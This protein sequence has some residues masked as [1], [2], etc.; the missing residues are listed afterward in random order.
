MYKVKNIIV[1][2]L[3]IASAC[4]LPAVSHAVSDVEKSFTGSTNAGGKAFTFDIPLDTVQSLN[5]TVSST[6]SISSA[7]NQR[8]GGF[9]L[10]GF[11]IETKNAN[12]G[13]DFL[14]AG[15][16]SVFEPAGTSI[17]G[18]GVVSQKYNET[19]E[20]SGVKLSTGS[21]R[22]FVDGTGQAPSFSGKYTLDTVSPVP[23]AETYAMFLAGLAVLGVVARRKKGQ[24]TTEDRTAF[25]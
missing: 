9:D 12:G 5:A 25:A 23:E 13:Y 2:G 11:Q 1:S 19:W 10:T 16:Q 20:I 3:I 17:G 4:F 24:I 8:N 21:Y 7:T 22:L 15:K 6:Y 14:I 18:N